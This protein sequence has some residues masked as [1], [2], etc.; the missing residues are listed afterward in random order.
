MI[1]RSE[2][3]VCCTWDLQV[4]NPAM[5]MDTLTDSAKEAEAV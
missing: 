3:V 2:F 4:I 1:N 5:E